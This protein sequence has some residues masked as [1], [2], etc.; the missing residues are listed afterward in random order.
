MRKDVHPVE[1]VQMQVRTT[2]LYLSMDATLSHHHSL[3]QEQELQLHWIQAA[4][5]LLIR[6][7]LLAL[8]LGRFH[9]NAVAPS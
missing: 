6:F 8:G 3:V 4:V 1:T 2:L 9:L 7:L 5:I